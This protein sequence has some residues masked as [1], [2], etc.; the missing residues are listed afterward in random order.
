MELISNERMR[1]LISQ[2]K[3]AALIHDFTPCGM[4]LAPRIGFSNEVYK[5]TLTTLVE[6]EIKKAKT[7]TED[8][9]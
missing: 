1:E 7:E 5:T 2:A 4:G 3:D 6:L 9:Q 8:A